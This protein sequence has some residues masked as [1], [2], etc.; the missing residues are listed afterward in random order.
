VGEVGILYVKSPFLLDEYLNNPEATRAATHEGYFTVGDMARV[1]EDG[2]YYIVDRAVDMII[3]G[4]VNIYPAEIEEVLYRH[5]D[6]F[7]VGIIGVPD[8]DWGEKIVAYVVRQPGAGLDE[9]GVV[10]HVSEN[11]ASYK[12]PREVVFVDEL[13]YSPS[14]KLLKRE[15]REMYKRAAERA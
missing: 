4:G 9:E 7:D 1:D 6:V 14:G 13:P 5:P 10:R 8:P 15:L 12:K 2:F 11:L 3:S